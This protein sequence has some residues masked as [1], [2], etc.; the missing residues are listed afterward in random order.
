M[1]PPGFRAFFSLLAAVVGCTGTES[2]LPTGTPP[3]T[4]GGGVQRAVLHVEVRASE[5][6]PVATA[7]GWSDGAVPA[8]TVTIVRSGSPGSSTGMTDAAGR[9]TFPDILPGTYLVS[10]VR[11]LTAAERATLAGAAITADAVGGAGALSVNAPSGTLAIS[12]MA[13]DRGSL[14]V[15]EIWSGEPLVGNTYYDH[16]DYFEI[17]NNSDAAVSLAD[18]IVF[19][20]FPGTYN[21]PDLDS[22]TASAPFQ[23]DSL[24]IWATFVYAFPPSAPQLPAGGTILLATDA[25]DHT[26]FTP[27][28]YD[29]RAANYE[30]RGGADTDNPSVPDMLSIGPSD[31][32][33]LSGRGMSFYMSHPVLAV[34]HA[35]DLASQPSMFGGGRTWVRIPRDALLD[36]VTWGRVNPSFE[37]CGSPVHAS[38]DAQQARVI[39]NWAVDLRAIT[40]RAIGTMPDGRA[41]LLRTRNSANDFVGAQPSPGR[42][43]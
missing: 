34:A 20:G 11:V 13:S 14:V 3:D 6:D 31:G 32:G 39:N 42:V 1:V 37:T 40:R 33:D 15:S 9:A 8:A 35:V 41:I 17:Y 30:F 29:L 2:R 28:A 23:R 10:A 18:K 24:G 43:P 12:M 36:V 38:L 19:A 25:I 4:T 21:N 26:F 27:L 5:S 7:L 22:C 16:G